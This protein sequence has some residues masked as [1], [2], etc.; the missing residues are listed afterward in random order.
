MNIDVK[1]GKGY[2]EKAI[3]SG[4]NKAQTK[5]RPKIYKASKNRQMQECRKT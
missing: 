4:S 1:R 5:R 2:N 3:A